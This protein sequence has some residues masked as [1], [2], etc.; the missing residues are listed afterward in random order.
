MCVELRIKGKP[1][2]VT[3]LQR[4]CQGS[5]EG[6]LLLSAAEGH[7]RRGHGPRQVWI[8]GPP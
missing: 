3:Y 2:Y 7:G 8:R 4:S 5:T 6:V 1:M